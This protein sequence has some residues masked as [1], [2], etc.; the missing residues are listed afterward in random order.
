MSNQEEYLAI[1]VASKPMNSKPMNNEERASLLGDADWGNQAN[2]EKILRKGFLKKVY[3]ILSIQMLVTVGITALF[4]MDDNVKTYTQNNPWVVYTSIGVYLFSA[5]AIICCGEL[6]RKHPHGLILLG[7]VTLSLSVMVGV[8]STMYDTFTVM[9]AFIITAGTTV[10]L[11]LYACTTKRDFTMMG[12]ALVAFCWIMLFSACLF[13]FFPPQETY[14]T[15]NIIYGSLGAFLM[16]LFIVYDT[17]LML[18]GKHKYAISMDEYVFAAL[19]LYLDIINLL[20]YIMRILGGG[21][22]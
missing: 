9:Y 11:S 10:G 4:V 22:K 21:R 14:Q 7:M 17:Q 1:P 19:N 2:M 5:L 3:G 6:R 15:W 18:G 12:G 8:I 16:C 20:L 13:W